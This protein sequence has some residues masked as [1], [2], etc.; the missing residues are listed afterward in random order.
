VQLVLT[1]ADSFGAMLA[2]CQQKSEPP[3][4]RVLHDMIRKL[5]EAPA[6]AKLADS[7]PLQLTAQFAWTEYEQL[8]ISEAVHRGEIVY[9]VALRIDPNSP[10]RAAAF[11]L[12]RNVLHGSGTVI[13]LRPED[14]VA[15]ATVEI[16]EAALASFQ[17]EERLL[18]RCRIPSIVSDVRIERAVT[19]GTPEHE[20]FGGLFEEEAAKLAAGATDAAEG[21]SAAF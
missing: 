4:V 12:I 20:W 18:Q 17:P 14:N 19:A 6:S 10:M 5:L 2:A 1:A 13:A 8:M 15:A 21:A 9:N 16:V 3:A 11:Q 7:A